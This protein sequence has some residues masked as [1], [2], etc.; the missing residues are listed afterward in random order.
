[1]K[2]NFLKIFCLIIMWLMIILTTFQ[3]NTVLWLI[4]SIIT[5]ILI[6]YMSKWTKVTTNVFPGLKYHRPW[7]KYLTI[8]IITGS[9][10]SI[11]RFFILYNSGAIKVVKLFPLSTK[12]AIISTLILLASNCYIAF[13]EEFVF[14]GYVIDALPCKLRKNIAIGISACLFLLA[15]SVNGITSVSRIIELLFLSLTLAIIYIKTKSLWIS[16]GLH[17][18]LDFFVFF[19]GGDGQASR[20]YILLTEKTPYYTDLMRLTDSIMP[21]ALFLLVIVINQIILKN[22]SNKITNNV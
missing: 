5:F 10:Y 1:M 14:R 22:S 2:G 20:Q 7:L 6:H 12:G 18:G 11:I 15:H 9:V 13:A 8:G 4:L 19:L 16:I 3:S 17:F 21:V